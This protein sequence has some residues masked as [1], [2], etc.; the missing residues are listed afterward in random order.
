MA[1][2]SDLVRREERAAALGTNAEDLKVVSGNDLAPDLA[3]ASASAQTDRGHAGAGEFRERAIV[4]AEVLVVGIRHAQRTSRTRFAEDDGEPGRS[5]NACD[6]AERDALE[7]REH[8][9]VQADA[10]REDADHGE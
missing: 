2:G 5:L 10:E 8:G 1:A 7:H 9:G 4:I 6:R 3:G